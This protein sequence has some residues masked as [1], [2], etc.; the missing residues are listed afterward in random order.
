MAQQI[1]CHQRTRLSYKDAFGYVIPI[2]GTS[3]MAWVTDEGMIG[4]AGFDIE[5]L[6]N[7]GVPAAV[8]GVSEESTLDNLDSLMDAEVRAANLPAVQR[9]VEIG[10]SGREALNRM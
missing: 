5:A 1:L 6:A 2:G 4:T 8:V 7:A 3:L 9:R 10:M